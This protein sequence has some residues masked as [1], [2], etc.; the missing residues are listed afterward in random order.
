MIIMGDPVSKPPMFALVF[1]NN[2]IVT[3]QD[4]VGNSGNHT[5]CARADEPLAVLNKCFTTY[6]FNTNGLIAPPPNYPPS[7]WP[8]N[9][10]FPQTVSAVDFTDYNNG[11]GGNYQL[12]SSS[13]YKNKGTDGKDLGADIAGLNQALANVE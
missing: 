5:S 11:N 2:L 8:K 1:T 9:N 7:T 4:P 10:M 6:T 12:L 13:P 3:G